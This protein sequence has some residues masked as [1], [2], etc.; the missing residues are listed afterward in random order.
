MFCKYCGHTID[1]DS[2]FCKDCGRK[3]GISSATIDKISKTNA[4]QFNSREELLSCA[5][6][7][8]DNYRPGDKS[9]SL[10]LD[11]YQMHL[12]SNNLDELLNNPD[13]FSLVYKTLC[14]WNMNQRAAKLKSASKL[15]DAV[16]GFAKE[17]ECL[18]NYHFEKLH[19]EDLSNALSLLEP[20]FVGLKPMD[21]ASQLV[22]TTKLLHFILPQLVMP[23][24]RKFTMNFFYG[25]S[26]YS[27]DVK[28]EFKTFK[29][30]YFKFYELAKNFNI[31]SD[32][33]TANSW[34]TT[35]PKLLDNAIIGKMFY[36]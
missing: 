7:T 20:I 11:L 23:M 14:A 34:N 9:L 15:A 28:E 10:Y 30:I 25:H 5:Q 4:K 13:F 19:E 18:C 6:F 2:I 24:D 17:V 35:V 16:R 21:S 3:L 1:D 36:S 12:R 33:L 27:S 31:T 22:G 26:I 29:N 8:T 32:D